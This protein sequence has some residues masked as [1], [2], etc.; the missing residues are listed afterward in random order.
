[1]MPDAKAW[2]LALL[3]ALALT[4]CGDKAVNGAN[5]NAPGSPGTGTSYNG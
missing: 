2:G 3:A 5:A 4:A 1:M